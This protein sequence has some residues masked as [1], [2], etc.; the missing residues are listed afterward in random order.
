[1]DNSLADRLSASGLAGVENAPILLTKKDEIP[2][3]IEVVKENR[4]CGTIEIVYALRNIQ[5]LWKE[6]H[7]L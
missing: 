3:L 7:L 6:K 1:M 4:V 2:D 5:H